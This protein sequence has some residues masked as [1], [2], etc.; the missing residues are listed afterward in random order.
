MRSVIDFGFGRNSQDKG[1]D[2]KSEM[3][4]CFIEKAKQL[5]QLDNNESVVVE[6]GVTLGSKKV[7]A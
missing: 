5:G 2:A 3:K 7:M 1:K 4:L 6:S